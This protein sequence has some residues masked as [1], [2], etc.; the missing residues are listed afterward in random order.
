MGLW[1]WFIQKP[2]RIRWRGKPLYRK[3][4]RVYWKGIPVDDDDFEAVRKNPAELRQ[5]NFWVRK[6]EAK[7]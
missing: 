7:I 3:G 6:R 2:K 5:Y 4:N 1:G